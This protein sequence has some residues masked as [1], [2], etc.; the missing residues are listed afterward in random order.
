MA[1][2]R[3]FRIPVEIDAEITLD[4]TSHTGIIENLSEEGL[5]VRITPSKSSRDLTAGKKFDLKFQL[6]SGE[7][8]NLFCRKIWS[9]KI[10]RRSLMK[11]VG[12]KIINPPVKYKQFIT[13]LE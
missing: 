8:L 3:T 10:T 1:K 4:E 2:E 9:F 12:M 13:T 5:C 11:R 6:P 7:T